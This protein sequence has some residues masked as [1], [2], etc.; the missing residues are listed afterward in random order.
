M[1]RQDAPTD[2]VQ[3]SGDVRTAPLPS[4]PV[5]R[6]ARLSSSGDQVRSSN[7]ASCGHSSM[8]RMSE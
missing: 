4:I 6:R 3:V 1:V 5:E 2:G 7:N 8:F